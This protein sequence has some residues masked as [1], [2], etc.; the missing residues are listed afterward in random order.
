M[1]PYHSGYLEERGLSQETIALFADHIRTG[2]KY[3]NT[4][5]LHEG[6][7]GITGFEVKNRGGFTGF[8]GG[9]E[10]A[11]FQCRVGESEPLERIVIAESAID[12]MSYY[13]LHPAEGLYLSIAGGLNPTQPELL[14]KT[15]ARYPNATIYI[16]KDNDLPTSQ[17]PQPEGE[18]Y[19]EIIRDLC[20]PTATV[21]R[22]SPL[23]PYKDWNDVLNNKPRTPKNDGHG[24]TERIIRKRSTAKQQEPAQ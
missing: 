6:E 17:H 23:E 10:K 3:N 1:Q 18:H 5:F 13:Q 4:C 16:A 8:A 15:L 20:P 24:H 12:A 7:T 22:A 2:G 19:Y 9:G 21:K 11:L 14:R